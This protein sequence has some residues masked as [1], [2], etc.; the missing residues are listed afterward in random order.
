MDNVDNRD[1]DSNNNFSYKSVPT[2][3]KAK[4]A[5]HSNGGHANRT[6]KKEAK[7]SKEGAAARLE[8]DP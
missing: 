4:E 8:L 5:K 2:L 6:E 7:H 3:K 1:H